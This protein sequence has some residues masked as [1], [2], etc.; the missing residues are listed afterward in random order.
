MGWGSVIVFVGG[1][2]DGTCEVLSNICGKEGRGRTLVSR[3]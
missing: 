2:V 1:Q 3:F